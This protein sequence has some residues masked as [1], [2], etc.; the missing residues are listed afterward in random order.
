MILLLVFFLLYR[1]CWVL[2]QLSTLERVGISSSMT[3]KFAL[4]TCRNVE[5]NILMLMAI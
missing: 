2:S 1:R 3:A 5:M 4:S